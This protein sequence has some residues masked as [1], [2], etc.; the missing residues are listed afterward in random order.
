MFSFGLALTSWSLIPFS[1]SAV[2]VDINVTVLALFTLSAFNIYGVMF[3]GW[4][5]NSRYAFLGAVRAAAQMISY[6]VSLGLIFLSVLVWAGSLNLFDLFEYQ[7]FVWA[8]FPFFPVAVI[9]FFSLL[10]ETARIP[11]DL[12]EAEGEL[13]SGYNVEYSASSF[14]FFFIA[15][16]AHVVLNTSLF[17]LIFLNGASSIFGFAFKTL[18]LLTAVCCIRAILPRYRYDLL[19]QLGWKVFLPLS[20]SFFIFTSSMVLLLS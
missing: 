11:F 17:A 10:A 5:S 20:L 16:Y 14:A 19:M 9:A 13:V 12:P 7:E 6:E 4:A 8:L 1:I 15:E 2:I 18:V 3:A